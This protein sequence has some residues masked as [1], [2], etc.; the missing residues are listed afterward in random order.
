MTTALELIQG[1]L[2]LGGMLAEEEPA[3]PAM[4]QDALTAFRQMIDLRRLEVR[5]WVGVV[6]LGSCSQTHSWPS[7]GM[8]A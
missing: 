4:M 3:G 2:R 1:S 5:R 6:V 7:S 8:P